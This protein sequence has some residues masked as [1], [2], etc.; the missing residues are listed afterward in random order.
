MDP[1]AVEKRRAWPEPSCALIRMYVGIN[2]CN[3]QKQISSEGEPGAGRKGTSEP[4][5]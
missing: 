3:V 2:L 4:P 1:G 5:A